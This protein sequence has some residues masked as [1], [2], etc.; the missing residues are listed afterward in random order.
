M[1]LMTWNFFC[2]VLQRA[3]QQMACVK[4]LNSTK[5]Q[6]HL[7]S[8]DALVCHE[9]PHL[10]FVH[11][12][13]EIQGYLQLQSLC[14]TEQVRRIDFILCCQVSIFDHHCHTVVQSCHLLQS[15][16]HE[17][18]VT[19]TPFFCVYAVLF[20][21]LTYFKFSTGNISSIKIFFLI[22]REGSK[23][24]MVHLQYQI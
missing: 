8:L 17:Q 24:K 16:C 5:C 21:F 14:E 18:A 13:G 19:F 1:C 7:Y 23:L 4:S 2:I 20:I 12:S 6:C 11:I 22:F 15:C 9:E 3:H 10:I